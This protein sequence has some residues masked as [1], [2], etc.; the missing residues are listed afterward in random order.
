MG[1]WYI[2]LSVLSVVL[3][4][5]PD[6][7]G[8]V[9]VDGDDGVGSVVGVAVSPIVSSGGLVMSWM[10]VT[11]VPRRPSIASDHWSLAR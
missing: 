7:V 9:G 11:G 5:T 10:R 6:V 3:C 4:L 2:L 1:G 8:L